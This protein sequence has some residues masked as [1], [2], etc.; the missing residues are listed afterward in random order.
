MA[1]NLHVADGLKNDQDYAPYNKDGWGQPYPYQQKN[2]I[3]LIR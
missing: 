2:P 1:T 3:L